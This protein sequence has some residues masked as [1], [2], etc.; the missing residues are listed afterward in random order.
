M[1]CFLPQNGRAESFCLSK[2]S[3]ITYIYVTKK[4]EQTVDLSL[5]FRNLINK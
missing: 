2:V 3:V 4:V 5:N 1:L